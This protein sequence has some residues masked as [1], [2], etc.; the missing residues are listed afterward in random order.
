MEKQDALINMKQNRAGKLYIVFYVFSTMFMI[1]NAIFAF[2]L[3]FVKDV[4]KYGVKVCI[5]IYIILNSKKKYIYIYLKTVPIK[6]Y[7]IY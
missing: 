5:F 3:L 7:F 4:N 1:F 6:L 2:L